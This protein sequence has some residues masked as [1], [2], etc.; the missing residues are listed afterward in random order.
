MID[1]KLDA[2]GDLENIACWRYFC[3]GEYCAGSSHQAALV[4]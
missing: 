4:L 3:Y 2:S 1:L